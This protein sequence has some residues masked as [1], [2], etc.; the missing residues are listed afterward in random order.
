M[1]PADSAGVYEASTAAAPSVEPHARSLVDDV[2]LRT[3]H[4]A[5]AMSLVKVVGDGSFIPHSEHIISYIQLIA[6]E[7]LHR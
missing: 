5:E 6:C 4:N 2:A 1:Y 3:R 7:E